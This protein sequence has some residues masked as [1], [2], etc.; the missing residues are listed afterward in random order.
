[1]AAVPY[2]IRTVLTDNG[3]QFVDNTPTNPEDEAAIEAY[4][5]ARGAPRL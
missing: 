5:A 2:T 1:V 3:T 4:G